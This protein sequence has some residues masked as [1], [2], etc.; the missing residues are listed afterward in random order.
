[1]REIVRLCSVILI[2][3]LTTPAMADQQWTI[4]RVSYTPVEGTDVEY[5]QGAIERNELVH[6][7][8]GPV[9][10]LIRV[11][12]GDDAASWEKKLN[13]SVDPKH[14][15]FRVGPP[16]AEEMRKVERGEIRFQQ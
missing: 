11:A 12:C 4:H 10:W 14:G 1:M 6:A 8:L 2:C 9:T 5:G 15:S 13:A 7:P 16:S 3:I